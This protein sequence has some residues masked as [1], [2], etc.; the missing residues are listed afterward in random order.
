MRFFYALAAALSLGLT[1]CGNPKKFTTQQGESGGFTYEF[2]TN[3][4]LNTR[5]YTL[6]NGLKVYLSAY[7]AEPRIMTSIA[8]KAGGKFD[9]AN[10]TGLAHYLEHIMFKGTSDFGTLDWTK[11]SP[12]L[13]SIEN[14]FETY[15]SITDSLKRMAHYQKIDKLSGEAAKLAIANEYDKMVAEMG[16]K[17]TNAY[18]TED[19]TVYIN[20]IPA[21]QIENWL[22]VEGNRFK[23]IVPRLF[24]TE[25]EAVYEEKNRSLDNDYWKTYETM[26]NTLF[27]KHPYGTQTVIGTIEHLKNP[28]ITE[29]KNYFY[30]YYRPNNVAVCLSGDLDFDKTIAMVEKYFGDWEPNPE[31]KEWT[32]IEEEPITDPIIKEVVG[33]DAE[34]VNIGFRFKGLS[35]RDYKLLTL[36]DMI[37]SNSQ[38]GLI[39]LNLKQQQKVLEPTCS[40]RAMNDYS[41]HLF[42]GQ[43]RE[44]QTLEEVKNLLLEQIELLKKGEFEDWLVEAVI[45]DLKKSRIRGYEQNYSRANELVMAFTNN[46]AW[47][48]YIGFIDDLRTFTKQD[49]IKFAQE[50]YK[51]NYVVVNKRTGKDPNSKRVIKP[52]ITKV[53]LNKENVSPFHQAMLDRKVEKLKPVFLDYEKDVKKTRMNG[54]VEVLYTTNT[55]NDLFSL[56]YL[57]DVG[58]NIDPRMKVAVEYIDYL[59]TADMSAEDFKKE[60]YKLGCDIGV[61]ATEDQTYV[62]L[63]GLT[64]NMDKAIQLFDKLLTNPKG[65][66]EALSK[67]VDGIFKKR[68]DVKKDKSAILWDGLMNYGLYGAQSSFTNVLTNKQLRELKSNEL[69]DVIKDFIKTEHRILYY[70]PKQ[71]NDLLTSL[72]A[73]HLLPE[74]LKPAPPAKNFE[75][76]DMAKPTVYWA[77]YDMV[78]AEIIFI[79]KGNQYDPALAA[80]TRM[81]NEYFGGS[82][83]SPVF[84][85]LRESQGLAYSA[86]AGYSNGSKK[87]EHDNFF[88]YIGTQADK[89][90]EAMNAMMN[91]IQNFPKSENGFDVAQ[92]SLLS[93]LESERIT[94]ASILFSYESAKRRGVDHDL[95]KDV[96]E[97]VQNMTIEDVA[98]FQKKHIKGKNFNIVLVGDKDKINLKQLAKFG[99]VRELTL[100][101]LFGYEKP[102]K[103]NLE[104]PNQ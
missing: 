74:Q 104:V 43:P 14:M 31:L 1:Q 69:M 19:R 103:V 45:N 84:Q 11:E 39:D 29:I 24:H 25:L 62:Y 27:A 46:I 82:M 36:T 99:E 4:P 76:V 66:D 93:Q 22:F 28:S 37:L 96:Y 77:D 61:S 87:G 70:G 56:Y 26:W 97:N 30:K 15:R 51:N 58:T 16:A 100:D 63:T 53:D 8:V 52:S 95:R 42:S 2:V 23:K 59:G 67:L 88:G 83:A 71:E 75:M 80:E 85:E 6:K 3:D 13:D 64:E 98:N 101:E 10:A 21:N 89:Q 44:G 90:P 86:F 32:P 9:P 65:D 91:L 60:L 92:K 17:Y 73:N 55:E 12:M 33:P 18:T 49:I 7:R 57:S 68:D 81:F 94:K 40:P 79:A 78:Q 102:Q 38:A 20:D 34:W 35:S 41:V 50:N 72:N 48:E 5:I 47:E 54:N